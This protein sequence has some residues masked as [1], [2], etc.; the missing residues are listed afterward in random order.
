MLTGFTALVNQLELRVPAP[1]VRSDIVQGARRTRIEDDRVYEQYPPSYGR[2]DRSLEHLRFGLRYEPIDLGVLAAFFRTV[3]K[4]EIQD[5][6]RSEPTGKFARRAWYL[7]ELLMD[8][9]LDIPDVPRTGAVPILDPGLHITSPGFLV[10]RQRV[11][12]NLLGNRDYCPLIR[13]TDALNET[14]LEALREAVNAVV[15]QVDPVILARAVQ[16]LYTKET[17]SSFAIER[18]TPSPDRTERFVNALSHASEFDPSQKEQFV[19][20]QNMIVDARYAQH[21]WRTIQN[22][23][24]QTASDWS[25]RVHYVCPKPEDVPSLM[26]GWM[27]MMKRL[28]TNGTHP[29][30]TAAAAAFGFVFIHPFE[31]GNGRIHRFLVHQA[32][33][34]LRFTPAGVLF[35]VSAA[36]LRDLVA[37]DRVLKNYSAAVMPF[38]EH[39]FNEERRLVVSNETAHLYRYIDATVQSEYLVRCI[40][41]TIDRDLKEEIGFIQVFDAA[42]KATI[43]IVDMPD[44]QAS[45]LVRFIMQNDGKLSKAKR[46]RFPELT[47]AEIQQIE[48]AVGTATQR[49]HRSS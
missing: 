16:Y 10:P 36:M 17:K 19:R 13:K 26:E 15:E 48:R 22:F 31:D 12:D 5:W 2:E 49:A 27:R 8:T 44:R 21:D 35:P 40:R 46:T 1:A 39:H 7:Y 28:E 37:Y 30:A 45:L 38:I 29:I 18:E 14:T 23:V 3:P 25:E 41:D 9:T 32:L 24:G 4:K 47:D 34:K 43:E 42:L 20:L 6:V 11:I 33:S